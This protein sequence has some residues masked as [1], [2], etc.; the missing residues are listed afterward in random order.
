MLGLRPPAG[1]RGQVP[2]SGPNDF[3]DPDGPR[4]AVLPEGGGQ[5]PWRP[6]GWRQEDVAR[7]C[8]DGPGGFTKSWLPKR[9]EIDAESAP[10]S[11]ML[12]SDADPRRASRSPPCW[13]RSP[14]SIQDAGGGLVPGRGQRAS[15][16]ER[17]QLPV[18]DR[19]GRASRLP[20][21]I[22][23]GRL[24]VRRLTSQGVLDRLLLNP[25]EFGF[26]A[27]VN[28]V[29]IL[30]ASLSPDLGTDSASLRLRVSGFRR[31]HPIPNLLN[32]IVV[33]QIVTAFTLKPNFRTD[34]V[35]DPIL[36]N[37]ALPS[38]RCVRIGSLPT[39]MA[40]PM[41]KKGWTSPEGGTRPELRA[42]WTEDAEHKRIIAGG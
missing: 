36:P 16:Q 29:P 27:L 6:L 19:A 23:N 33:C 24:I 4:R 9:C 22:A 3:H 5:G 14:S 37:F 10:S 12:G 11:K 26:G 41:A 31:A 30:L 17:P 1:G 15:Q 8:G 13:P 40:A 28:L 20:K 42:L 39:W 2:R 21:S 34:M 35:V 32:C 38:G 18:A 7:T 25:A